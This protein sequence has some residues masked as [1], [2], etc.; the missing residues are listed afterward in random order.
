MSTY[1][2]N[3]D[4]NDKFQFELAGHLYD[5]RYPTV[6][7]SESIQ[8]VIKKAQETDDTQAVL[9]EI[10]QYITSEDSKTPKID[11]I[12]PKQ[13]IKVLRNFTEMIKVEV[14]GE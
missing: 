13:N 2:L 12:L 5:F 1:N 3:D 8:A 4:V 7:E 14:G 10:Y 11:E 6:E 9:N